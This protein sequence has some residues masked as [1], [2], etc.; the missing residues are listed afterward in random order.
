MSL[1]ILTRR[2]LITVFAGALLVRVV[3]L[4]FVQQTPVQFDARRYVGAALTLPFVIAEPSLVSDTAR[5]NQIDFGKLYLAKVTDEHVVWLESHP[6]S[7]GGAVEDIFF[8]GPVYPLL[9]SAVLNLAPA[10]D[11]WVLRFVQA[12]IDSLTAVMIW[13]LARRLVSHGAAWWAAGLWAGYGPAVYKTGEVVT[14]T[15]SIAMTVAAAFLLVHAT[16]E[17]FRWRA[18]A[19]A[20][21]LCGL[22]ILTRAAAMGLVAPLALAWAWTK[23]RQFRHVLIGWTIIGGVIALTLIPWGGLVKA[24]FG[25]FGLRDPSY[26]GGNFRSSNMLAGEG[27]DLDRA[28]A[29]FWTY[30][31]WREIQDQPLEY[32]KLYLRKLYRLWSRPYDDF[33]QGY[34]FGFDVTIWFHRMI[35]ILAL[36]G[37]L[38][39]ATRA[40]PG[41]IPLGVILY[42]SLLHMAFHVVARYNMPAMPFAII[43]ATAGFGWLLNARLADEAA[44]RNRAT[45]LRRMAIVVIG[46]VG[47]LAVVR[48][49]RPPFWLMLDSIFNANSAVWAFWLAGV[50]GIVGGVWLLAREVR[51]SPNRRNVVIAGVVIVLVALFLTQ[52]VPREGHADWSAVLDRPG[53]EARRV[54][55]L[56]PSLTRDSVYTAFLALDLAAEERRDCRVTIT[57]DGIART[58]PVDSLVSDLYFYR[59]F[60]YRAFLNLYDH[61]TCD[62]RQWVVWEISRE[63][64]DSMMADHRLDIRVSAAPSGP[65]PGGLLVYGDM[66]VEDYRNWIGPTFDIHSVERYYEGGDPRIWGREPLD[67]ARAEC[68][69]VS[70]GAGRTD[71]LSDQPGRQIG[72]YRLFV[73]VVTTSRRFLTF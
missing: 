53:E 55:Y 19:A 32:A 29:D 60:V 57:T 63:V 37:V 71:D 54:T 6:P 8:A 43:A 18:L 56:P 67:F 31:V 73:T 20:G 52:A 11:F 42:V 50:L 28:P 25:S 7:F 12:I 5:Q 45:T 16:D 36:F 39:W 3:Y 49:L 68:E 51:E 13:L 17:R 62:V 21:L 72:Q 69:F 40:G 10:H 26:A 38:V 61:R 33:R 9:V 66:P 24:R 41:L 30:P 4:L 47:M 1:T 58:K 2:P 44:T 15:V 34:P 35:V 23:R 27:Y 59:K 22:L 64:I 48:L 46:L 14:E 70:D 65:R